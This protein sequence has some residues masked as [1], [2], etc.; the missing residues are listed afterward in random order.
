MQVVDDKVLLGR[1]RAAGTLWMWV[2]AVVPLLIA[3]WLY[4]TGTLY[5][6]DFSLLLA[7]LLSPFLALLVLD[8]LLAACATWSAKR[9]IVV[10]SLAAMTV[11][12]LAGA[13]VAVWW[14]GYLIGAVLLI[15]P[16]LP[17]WWTAGRATE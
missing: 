1:V 17:A 15:I 14:S 3:I 12:T 9:T 8:M 7:K 4:A 5:W 6:G 16:L 11:L 13:F 10:G 2:A